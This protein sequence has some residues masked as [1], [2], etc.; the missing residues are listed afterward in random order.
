MDINTV[1]IAVTLISFA[2]FIVIVL[3]AV[4]PKSRAGF[5]EASRLPFEEE[6]LPGA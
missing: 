5:E 1:R 2:I 6:D 3:W 4:N